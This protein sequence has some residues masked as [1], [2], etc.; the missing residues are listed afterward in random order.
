METRE[1]VLEKLEEKFSEIIFG[2]LK[3]DEY[4]DITH[5]KE[6]PKRMA[7]MYFDELLSGVYNNPD[8]LVKE[9]PLKNK[10]EQY[11]DS[12]APVIVRDIE[13]RSLC[14]HHFMPFYGTCDIVYIPDKV[15]IGLS[16]FSRISD[17]FSRKPQ[18]Q[19]VLTKEIL[20]FIFDKIDPLAI[21]VKIKATHLCMKHR[22]AKSNG[23]MET[24]LIKTKDRYSELYS[25]IE[26]LL[27]KGN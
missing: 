26:N 16:K 23:E 22:G 20:E 6:T 17:H 4:C 2:V 1:K 19:E 10:S 11:Q 5:L 3:L 12:I 15:L 8:N 24:Y 13:I 21:G 25:V 7:K 9:F 14:S 27:L 18:V